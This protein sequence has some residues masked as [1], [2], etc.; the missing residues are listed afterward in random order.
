[1]E[2][3]ELNLLRRFFENWCKWS[4]AVDSEVK[5]SSYDE[6]V[7]YYKI[8]D[9]AQGTILK[10]RKQI[11]EIQNKP[12]MNQSNRTKKKKPNVK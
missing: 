12:S 4:D 2:Q 10:L 7:P 5:C 9:K 1:M 6:A 3:K 11:E 8:M